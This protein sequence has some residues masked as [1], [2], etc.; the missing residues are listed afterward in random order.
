MSAAPP[1]DIARDPQAVALDALPTVVLL[2]GLART[3]WSMAGLQRHLERAGFPTWARSYP[4]RRLPIAGAADLIA[5]WIARDLPAGRPLAAVTHSLGGIVVRH[6]GARV[7]FGR[8]VMLAPPNHGS[9]VSRA[10]RDQS[11]YRWFYGPAGQEMAAPVPDLGH[12][13][14]HPAAPCTVAVIAGTR[15][16]AGA[17]PTSWLT[18]RR[19]TFAA[20]EPNDGTLAVAETELDGMTAF[21]TVDASHTWIMDDPRVRALCVA[22]LRDGRLDAP[23]VAT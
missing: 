5:S 18:R 4:S 9:R 23:R 13:W 3:R 15:A 7:P 20:G 17:N 21:A 10:L 22:F 19:R 12:R 11:I 16:S 6:I 14:P 8:V 1:N 2:H